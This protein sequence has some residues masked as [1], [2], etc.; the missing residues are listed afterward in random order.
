MAAETL[1]IMWNRNPPGEQTTVSVKCIRY[2]FEELCLS[3]RM[4]FAQK[5]CEIDQE[6]GE[7]TDENNADHRP[8]ISVPDGPHFDAFFQTSKDFSTL[9]RCLYSRSM[10]SGWAGTKLSRTK[11]PSI[12]V[13]KGLSGLNSVVRSCGISSIHSLSEGNRFLFRFRRNALPF[14][15]TRPNFCFLMLRNAV[16]GDCHS[17]L[18]GASFLDGP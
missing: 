12:P 9:P 13:M 5:C 14:N 7:E 1:L 4:V 3:N 17:P 16:V 6:S 2:F 15:F 11:K 18:A 8:G 10:F